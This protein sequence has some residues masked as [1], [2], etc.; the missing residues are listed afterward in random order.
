MK[1]NNKGYMLVEVIIASAIALIMAYFLIDIT[2]TLTNKNND[3]YVESTLITDKNLITKEIMDD[4]N[5]PEYSLIEIS[6]DIE[7]DVTTATLNYKSIND[8]STLERELIINK[9]T[10]EIKY[11]EYTKKLDDILTIR[12]FKIEKDE[13]QKQLYISIPAYTNYSDVDYGINLVIPYTNDI[14]VIIPEAN[15]CD[16]TSGTPNSP[17]LVDGL[18][19]VAYDESKNSWVK[20]DSTNKNDSWYNYCDKKWANAVLVGNTKRD[21]YKNASVGTKINDTDIMAFYVWI[22]RYKYKVWDIDKSI[23]VSSYDAYHTGIDIIFENNKEK[24]GTISCTYNFN[25]DTGNGGINLGTT[26]AETCTGNNGDYY[27]HPA[28]TFGSDELRGIWVGKFEFV[29]NISGSNGNFF[30]TPNSITDNNI[31]RGYHFIEGAESIQTS[32]KYGLNTSKTIVDSHMITNLEWGTV[33]Y[34]TNSSFGRCINNVC[35]E[36]T[37]NNCSDG[38]TGIGGDEVDDTQSSKTCDNASNSYNGEKGMLAS[39][40]GN[41]TGIY[42]MSGDRLEYVAGGMSY[43]KNTFNFSL[44]DGVLSFKKYDSSNQKYFTGYAFGDYSTKSFRL[45]D[46]TIETYGWYNDSARLFNGTNNWLVR[47]GNYSNLYTAGIFNFYAVEDDHA[48][49]GSSRATL[50]SLK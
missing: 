25:V 28:F 45:G 32:G 19:P 18:I 1:L 34:L 20:A 2:I 17:D 47:G 35:E 42:D 50:I 31:L 15:L 27:T 37:V 6:I 26:S 5:N 48:V 11:G 46:A 7:G 8:N 43:S 33:A 4:V 21:T 36:V 10:N 29:W 38:T 40:T 41:V 9:N 44:T 3:Y 16:L 49:S 13:N 22:P 39:T 23:N 14:E 12:D 30:M 24:T